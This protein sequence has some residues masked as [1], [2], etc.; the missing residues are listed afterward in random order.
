ML[1]FMA[2]SDARS[3]Y[4]V[5]RVRADEWRQL[6]DIRL[7][8]LKDTPIGFGEWYEDTLAK[9]E[10]DWR[11]RAAK[12]AQSAQTA[13]FVAVDEH[14][15]FVGTAGAFPKPDTPETR[16]VTIYAVYVTPAHRGA[17]RGVASLLFDAVIGWSREV[18]A[19]QEI[20]LSVHERNDRA[21]AF[22]RRYGF[23]DTGERT[24]YILD[25]SASLIEMRYEG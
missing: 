2:N 6:R 11:E 13:M 5:R 18:G 1:A 16:T 17:R 8:A 9:P 15:R 21:H 25:D 12:V 19:A 3:H 24:A 10:S 20:R 22:Y 4:D 14:G 7:E 23:V